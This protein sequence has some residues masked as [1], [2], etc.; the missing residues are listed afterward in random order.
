MGK[1]SQIRI[2]PVF[3]RKREDANEFEEE[4]SVTAH[5]LL[6]LLELQQQLPHMSQMKMLCFKVSSSCSET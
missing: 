6:P 3:K 1:A 4:R 5:P 2:D